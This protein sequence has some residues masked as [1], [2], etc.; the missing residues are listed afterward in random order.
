MFLT[1]FSGQRLVAITVASLHT[2]FIRLSACSPP[3]PT[4]CALPSFTVFF[5]EYHHILPTLHCLPNLYSSPSCMPPST[6]FKRVCAIVFETFCCQLYYFLNGVDKGHHER[7][8][9]T[10]TTLLLIFS[11]SIHTF[12]HYLQVLY[13]WTCKKSTVFFLQNTEACPKWKVR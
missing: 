8:S 11:L 7:I 12:D 6:T 2:V 1:V 10:G 3:S 4:V 9:T 5:S 13:N